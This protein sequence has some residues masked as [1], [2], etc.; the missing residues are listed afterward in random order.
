V[1]VAVSARRWRAARADQVVP[2]RRRERVLA[3]R[4]L[5]L[6]AAVMVFSIANLCG[7]RKREGGQWR[8]QCSGF[9]VQGSGFRIQNSVFRVRGSGPRTVYC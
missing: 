4:F 9:R 2:E 3:R 5:L 6:V 8:N 1:K 7:K